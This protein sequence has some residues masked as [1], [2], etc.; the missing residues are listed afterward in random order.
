[1][2]PFSF[3]SSESLDYP[4]SIRMYDSLLWHFHR[5]MRALTPWL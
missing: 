2:D 5:A 3:A 4:V 1:M